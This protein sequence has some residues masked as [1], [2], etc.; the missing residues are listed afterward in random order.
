MHI[1]LWI[2][3]IA[4]LLGLGAFIV[5]ALH[6]VWV[7][8]HQRRHHLDTSKPKHHHPVLHW[9]LSAQHLFEIA[10]VAVGVI[11]T[12]YMILVVLTASG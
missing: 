5:H 11:V 6:D 12:W 4:G 9:L 2:L 3:G 7:R 1:A 8:A 10:I